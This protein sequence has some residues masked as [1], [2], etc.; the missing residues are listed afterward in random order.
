MIIIGEKEESS[1]TVSIRDRDQ[2]EI[3]QVKLSDFIAHLNNEYAEKH[4]KPTFI[5]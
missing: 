4:L 2:S 3:S 5:K 1:G